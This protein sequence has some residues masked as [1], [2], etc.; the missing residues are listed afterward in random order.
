MRFSGAVGMTPVLTQ[1]EYDLYM[2]QQ[3][4]TQNL[5]IP[6]STGQ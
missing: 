1:T 6:D 4:T 3:F 5:Q 2:I